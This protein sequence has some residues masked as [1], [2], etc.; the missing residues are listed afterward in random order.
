MNLRTDWSEIRSTEGR[1]RLDEK[2]AERGRAVG[3]I[4]HGLGQVSLPALS[5]ERTGRSQL[6]PDGAYSHETLRNLQW[7]EAQKRGLE[8]IVDWVGLPHC[9]ALP[10]F[11]RASRCAQ[12]NMRMDGT[13]PARHGTVLSGCGVSRQRVGRCLR[14][15]GAPW[16]VKWVGIRRTGLPQLR[17]VPSRCSKGQWDGPSANRHRCRWT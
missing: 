3:R 7:P 2:D 4:R 13:V 10:D 6:W 12:L 17:R 14:C 1:R 8:L 5:R 9:P 16:A 11:R 15:R